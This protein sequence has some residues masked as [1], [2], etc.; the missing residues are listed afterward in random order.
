MVEAEAESAVMCGV[1]MRYAVAGVVRCSDAVEV[2]VEDA[3]EV[4]VEDA[5]EVEVEDAVCDVVM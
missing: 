1:M 3:V 4:E 5:V 2:A